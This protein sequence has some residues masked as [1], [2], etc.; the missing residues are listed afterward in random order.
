LQD[1]LS[2]CPLSKIPELQINKNLFEE[3]APPPKALDFK[4]NGFVSSNDEE[5]DHGSP[6]GS[7]KCDSPLRAKSDHGEEDEYDDDCSNSSRL[8]MAEGD[9]EDDRKAD[10]DNSELSPSAHEENGNHC[11]NSEYQGLDMS[12]R[13]NTK[14]EDENFD[15]TAN[16]EDK[17]DDHM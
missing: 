12:K 14:A 3:K 10:L 4:K 6:H 11:S 1:D 8:V 15:C 17:M 2:D 16:K 9:E 5:K 13:N 7:D